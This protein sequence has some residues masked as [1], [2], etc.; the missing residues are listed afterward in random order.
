MLTVYWQ[1]SWACNVLLLVVDIVVVFGLRFF[2]VDVQSP[3]DVKKTNCV[4]MFALFH[5]LSTHKSTVSKL[6]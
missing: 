1:V 5:F 2:K 4:I 3:Y 6:S